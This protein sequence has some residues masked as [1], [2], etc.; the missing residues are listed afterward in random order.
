VSLLGNGTMVGLWVDASLA[1][2]VSLCGSVYLGFFVQFALAN[3]A[4]FCTLNYMVL[5]CLMPKERNGKNGKNQEYHH[6]ADLLNAEQPESFN[7]GKN[8]ECHQKNQENMIHFSSLSPFVYLHFLCF[9]FIKQSDSIL[10]RFLD[11]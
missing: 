3:N 4:A 5:T 2:W 9:S 6:G 11:G 10:T 1:V 7:N 8:Q